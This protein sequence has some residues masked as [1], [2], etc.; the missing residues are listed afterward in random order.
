MLFA[1]SLF[2]NSLGLVTPFTGGWLRLWNNSGFA[3]S[4]HVRDTDLRLR[5]F[6]LLHFFGA[7]GMTQPTFNRLIELGGDA[8]GTN[9]VS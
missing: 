1:T 9:F 2:S 7:G 5:K 8:F 6:F 4:D 3:H